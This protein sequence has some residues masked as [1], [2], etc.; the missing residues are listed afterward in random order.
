[1]ES[2]MNMS[3]LKFPILYVGAKGEKNLYTLFDSGSEF[4]CVSEEFIKDIADPAKL[5]RPRRFAT[6]SDGHYMEVTEALHLDFYIDDVLLS[7]N[8]FVVPG[9]SEEAII[10]AGTFQKYRMKL[11]F[12][13]DRVEVNSKP[14]YYLKSYRITEAEMHH[15]SSPYFISSRRLGAR[16]YTTKA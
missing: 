15:N 7:D 16:F 5:G 8:F 14:L 6:A 4:S 2:E 3:I 10:G 13:H 12:E 11:N 9:L 1:V